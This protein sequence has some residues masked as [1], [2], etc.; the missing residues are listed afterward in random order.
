MTDHEL[1]RAATWPEY[2]RLFCICAAV[3]LALGLI[4]PGEW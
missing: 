1:H 3:M 2:I 4:M